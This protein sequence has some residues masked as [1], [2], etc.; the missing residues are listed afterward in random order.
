MPGALR[1]SPALPAVWAALIAL[2]L[3]WAGCGRVS[4]PPLPQDRLLTS[5]ASQPITE[6]FSLERLVRERE[7]AR[8]AAAQL[9]RLCRRVDAEG[10]EAT[11]DAD[12][13]LEKVRFRCAL[14]AASSPHERV[15]IDL[16]EAN[17][18][19]L[20]LAW[21]PA[22]GGRPADGWVEVAEPESVAGRTARYRTPPIG[23]AVPQGPRHLWIDATTRSGLSTRLEGLA[24]F[25]L[26]SDP[27]RLAAAVR[28]P[29]IFRQAD[30]WRTGFPALAG[31]P[32]SWNTAVPRAARLR[33]E[34][35]GGALAGNAFAV[36]F[37]LP[38]EG[39]RMLYSGV[40]DA[41]AWR[42]VD[43]DL[44]QLDGK[45]GEL[46]FEVAGAT[47]EL[48]A[49]GI[50]SVPGLFA[51]AAPAARPHVLLISID[52]LRADHLSLQGSARATSPR[53]DRWAR[54]RGVV[55]EEAMAQ[56]PW[57]LPSHVSILTGLDPLH[58][59][60]NVDAAAARYRSFDNLPLLLA[61]N[62]YRTDAVTGGGFVHPSFGFALGFD[63]YHFW[64]AD[65][66]SHTELA[67]GIDRVLELFDEDAASPR[68]VFLHTYEVHPP[69]RARQPFFG[70]MSALRADLEVV[71]RPGEPSIENG[72]V[73]QPS[74]G[75]RS[76]ESSPVE[77]L[78]PDLER[79]PADVY[80]S[81]IAYMDS[82]VGRLLD[83][84][85]ARGLTDNLLVVFTSD[86][87]ES[88]G[89][90]GRWSHGHLDG[91]NL[92][93]PLVVALPGGR[94][95]GRRVAE[96][97]RSIDILPTILAEL[98]IA[99][100]EPLDGESLLEWI[101]DE[102]SRR[103][104]RE[105]W[106]YGSSNNRGLVLRLAPDRMFLLQDSAYPPVQGQAAKLDAQ[107]TPVAA[108]T[109]PVL[110]QIDAFRR[111]A[112]RRW[113][114]RAP[115][116]RVTFSNPGKSA[117]AGSLRSELIDGTTVKSW[118]VPPWGWTWA[119]RGRGR[120]SVAP[121][122]AFSVLLQDRGRSSESVAGEVELAGCK[123]AIPFDLALEDD[124]RHALEWAD[125]ACA[126]AKTPSA[127]QA[128]ARIATITFEHRGSRIAPGSAAN[129]E[130]DLLHQQL[131]ALG[132]N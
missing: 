109:A 54:E 6:S 76:S 49:W 74:L 13:G 99:A 77:P 25:A 63:R 52:T 66:D 21:S 11:L 130:D 73:G 50:W 51:P 104:N 12:P 19:G 2:G 1:P 120:F 112:R 55:F 70:E 92:H 108:P 71:G 127:V 32:L 105:G 58:H 79:L 95:A 62:G 33:F 29:W 117:F 36:K 100:R 113:E 101:D 81:S 97:V 78:S 59:G 129:A 111:A 14:P 126:F 116:I 65:R 96:L 90:A 75:V 31:Y 102:A 4:A 9:V 68:F 83:G 28:A 72:F 27:K 44:S 8:W 53:I 87:G 10:R 115:G 60:V 18:T 118:D 56:A 121:G 85:A 20:R 15:E 17:R 47:G 64:P 24:L 94:G 106:A 67:F 119:G 45:T 22:G 38:G 114:E 84:L 61:R 26:E 30:E 57:T 80:D 39:E 128:G 124:V 46:R 91:P 40:G 37:V 131:R 34:Y 98:G 5:L 48:P 23:S 69:N 123:G 82:E 103:E 3:S 93:V 107:W 41:Q 16:A 43:I 132:Y 7:V 110:A 88:L 42:S 89:E 86:H 122:S 35:L 125:G